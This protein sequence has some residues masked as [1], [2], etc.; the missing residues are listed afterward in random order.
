MRGRNSHQPNEEVDGPPLAFHLVRFVR[1]LF[2]FYLQ[3]RSGRAALDRWGGWA[4]PWCKG[5][6]GEGPLLTSAVDVFRDS[7]R[8]DVPVRSTSCALLHFWGPRHSSSPQ[9]AFGLVSKPALKTC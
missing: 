1:L 7:V 2:A 5:D 3:R 4:G 6:G 9:T 8:S